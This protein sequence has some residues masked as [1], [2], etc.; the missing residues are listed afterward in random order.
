M[1]K[2]IWYSTTS[3]P[4]ENVPC[5]VVILE[6][7]KIVGYNNSFEQILNPECANPLSQ[8]IFEI[9]FFCKN[10]FLD[11]FRNQL[12]KGDEV[13]DF[14]L[15]LWNQ[16]N[17]GVTTKNIVADTQNLTYLFFNIPQISGLTDSLF[18]L[19]FK[20][21]KDLLDKFDFWVV[22]FDHEGKIVLCNN[23]FEKFTAKPCEDILNKTLLEIFPDEEFYR[24]HLETNKKL[25]DKV[26]QRV[27]LHQKVRGKEGKEHYLETTKILVK[28]KNK[29]YIFCICIDTNELDFIRQLFEESSTLYRTLIENAFDAIYLMK[30]RRYVYV[31]PRFC[32]LTG[33]SEAELT[34][35]N[36]DFEVLIPEESRK[37][38]EWRYKMRL[39]GKEIPSQYELQL[40][41]KSGNK[42]YV[43]VSTVSVGKPGEVV[44]MGIMRDITDRKKF[45]LELKKSEQRLKELNAA[46]DKFFNILAHDL[47]A[48][49][50][51]LIS[52]TK[53]LLED[54]ENLTQDDIKGL[55]TNLL[56]HTQQTY[57][58]LE[59]LLQWAKT[60]TGTIH[61]NPEVTDLYEIAL[62]AKF[63]NETNAKQKNIQ[64]KNNIPPN[65]LSYIDQNMISTALRNLISNAV[66]F[67]YPGGEIIIDLIDK[68][69]CYELTVSDTGVGMSEEQINRLF[70]IGESVSTEGTMQEKGSGLGLILAKE[71]IEKNNGSIR[72]ES[73]LGKGSKFILTLPK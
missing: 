59:N 13:I 63:V 57:N 47:R 34:S 12:D 28:I 17:V 69:N 60:Q 45:E 62:A 37:Y 65:S 20:D 38:L 15:I 39:E 43:E 42:V 3:I 10:E 51:G 32:E 5:P 66:K 21:L 31:N 36:F 68:D 56:N 46:K 48:P 19:A 8:N 27:H 4:L 11:R 58:L 14:Q 35:E 25:F 23:K 18:G 67:T 33:Y 2:T 52:I 7:N 49:L 71:F 22:I 72:V 55:L 44:V 70:D 53:T 24:I 50:S 6:G 61:F 16:K 30:G 29:E 26:E 64:I 73:T 41:H 1:T 54:Y 9:G 40:L